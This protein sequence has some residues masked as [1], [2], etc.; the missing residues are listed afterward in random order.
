MT[1]LTVIPTPYSTRVMPSA[2]PSPGL[3]VS[4]IA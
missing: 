2:S 3:M 1:M 4:S